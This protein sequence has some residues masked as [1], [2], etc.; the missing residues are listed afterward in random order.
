Q[1]STPRHDGGS[2]QSAAT[3]TEGTPATAVPRAA[4][5]GR[6]AAPS[7]PGSQCMVQDSRRRG[8]E[9]RL[10]HRHT[11]R[12]ARIRLGWGGR[13]PPAASSGG[14]WFVEHIAEV[15]DISQS[16]ICLLCAH[17]PPGNREIWVATAGPA[18]GTWSRVMLKSLSEPEFGRFLLRLTFAESCPYD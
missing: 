16:G 3:M 18:A 14:R 12:N 8:Q 6:N 10:C 17:V 4:A 11:V 15:L 13:G 9:R 5:A 2:D 7:R 1:H